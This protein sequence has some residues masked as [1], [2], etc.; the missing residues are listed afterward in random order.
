MGH[1]ISKAVGGDSKIDNI[2]PL[3]QTCNRQMSAAKIDNYCKANGHQCM[4][5]NILS[6]NQCMH[7][8]F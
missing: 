8:I 1:M 6:A 2:I 4:Y 7:I 5:K 3:C